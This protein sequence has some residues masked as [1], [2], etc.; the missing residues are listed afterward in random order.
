M[1]QP[2]LKPGDRFKSPGC[3]NEFEVIGACCQLFDRENLPYPSCNIQ[4]KG[5][6]PSWRRVGKRFI[7]DISSKNQECYSVRLLDYENFQ[8]HR[9]WVF[10]YWRISEELK[11]W[12]NSP[13][14]YKNPTADWQ[15]FINHLSK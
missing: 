6:Q 4:W 5:K 13:K 12:W 15:A 2:T 7:P 10:T 11:L 3:G 9:V 8:N 1:V 14:Q